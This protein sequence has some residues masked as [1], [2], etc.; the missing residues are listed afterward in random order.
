MNCLCYLLVIFERNKWVGTK[1]LERCRRRERLSGFHQIRFARE[2]HP[3]RMGFVIPIGWKYMARPTVKIFYAPNI[4]NSFSYTAPINC[5]WTV[6]FSFHLVPH[7]F[8]RFIH[9]NLIDSKSPQVLGTLLSIL[10][11]LNHTAVLMVSTYHLIF[12][13]SNLFIRYLRI[14]PSASVTI[15]ITV[16]FIFHIFYN[17]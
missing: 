1:M 16:T 7:L 10:A 8:L 14:I 3:G 4:R 6:L 11:N 2:S 5:P 13:L 9:W 15:D 12:N 17:F